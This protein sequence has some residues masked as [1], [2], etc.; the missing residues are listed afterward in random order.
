MGILFPPKSEWQVIQSTSV[1]AIRASLLRDLETIFNETLKNCMDNVMT[2]KHTSIEVLRDVLLS[3]ML[4]T[5][6]LISLEESQPMGALVV[7]FLVAIAN[8]RNSLCSLPSSKV[9]ARISIPHES[10]KEDLRL[11]W[12]NKR[13]WLNL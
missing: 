8:W 10:L 11:T 6:N 7:D 5:T 1:V 12:K 3:S 4:S 2:D 9:E 13:Q